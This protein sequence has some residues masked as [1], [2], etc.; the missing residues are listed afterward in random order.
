MS[1]G[2]GQRA[3]QSRGHLASVGVIES[4]GCSHVALASRG[5]AEA[6]HTTPNDF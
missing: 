2:A 5:H 6:F 4:I 3:M 1:F